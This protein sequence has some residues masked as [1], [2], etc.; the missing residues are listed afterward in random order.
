MNT[1]H[2]DVNRRSVLKAAVMFAHAPPSV[3][4][5]CHPQDSWGQPRATLAKASVQNKSRPKI[6]KMNPPVP[7]KSSPAASYFLS[8]PRLFPSLCVR[9]S[10]FLK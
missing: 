8:A 2:A 4:A 10:G 1:F 7:N 5:V 9:Q 3:T 6:N